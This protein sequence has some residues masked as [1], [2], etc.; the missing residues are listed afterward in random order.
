MDKQMKGSL[1]ILEKRKWEERNPQAISQH[2]HLLLELSL[3]IVSAHCVKFH[4]M[5]FHNF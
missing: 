4:Y 3:S 2:P 1:G 5:Y